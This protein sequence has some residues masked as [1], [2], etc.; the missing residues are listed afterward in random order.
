V[1]IRSPYDQL[2]GCTWLARIVDKIRR[3]QEGTLGEEYQEYL[4]NPSATDGLFLYF[5]DLDADELV[6]NVC[7]GLTD[8]EL[9]RWFLGLEEATPEMIS[10]WN[11]F[12]VSLG[13]K[14]PH[15]RLRFEEALQNIY[16][17]CDDPAV[18][19]FYDVIDWDEGRFPNPKREQYFA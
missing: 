17:G 4:C 18:Q 9:E 3:D 8:E 1:N 2:A 10:M 13:T 7:K 15:A 16:S 5:F 6:D 14:G 12:A 11:D 19:T